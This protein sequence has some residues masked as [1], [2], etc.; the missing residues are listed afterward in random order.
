MRHCCRLYM[1]WVGAQEM[2]YWMCA[3][4]YHTNVNH[5]RSFSPGNRLGDGGSLESD[6]ST[7][8]ITSQWEGLRQ[9]GRAA[10]EVEGWCSCYSVIS[11]SPYGKP[12]ELGWSF[13]VVLNWG[14]GVGLCA[15]PANSVDK[16]LDA[17]WP[18]G[19]GRIWGDWL[20]SA[21]SNFWKRLSS[22]Q[23]AAG[24]GG[25]ECLG[26][27]RVIWAARH[28]IHYTILFNAHENSMN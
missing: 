19:G 6:V 27:K 15:L 26:P 9:Q 11:Q 4:R 10:G 25:E 16:L 2:L 13:R 18:W 23:S 5:C 17:G 14:K 3:V 7:T 22:E 20:P 21:N 12:L 8:A 1:R 28:S 24:E